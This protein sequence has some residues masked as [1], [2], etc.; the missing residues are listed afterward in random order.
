MRISVVGG[1]ALVLL[2]A[3]DVALRVAG[4]GAFPWPATA[5]LGMSLLTLLAY[6]WDKRRAVSGGRRVPENTLHVLALCGGW[7]G[8]WVGRPLF[9]H[10]TRKQPFSTIFWAL[11]VL[12]AGFWL[13]FAFG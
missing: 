2:L 7:P 10:K 9:R 13:W 1:V 11:G 4:R 6:G 5:Y 12:H 8:A 3:V